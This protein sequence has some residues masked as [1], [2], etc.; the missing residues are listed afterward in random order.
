MLPLS[1]F[2]RLIN[3]VAAATAA[4][5]LHACRLAIDRE[6]VEG[7][8]MCVPYVHYSPAHFGVFGDG[9]TLRIGMLNAL[10]W[11]RPG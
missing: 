9:R 4:A 7:V 3:A 11:G 10:V 2:S 8:C 6:G 1:P 5:L